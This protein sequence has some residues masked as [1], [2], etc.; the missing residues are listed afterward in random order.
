MKREHHYTLSLKWTGNTGEGTKSYRSYKREHIISI[1]NKPD[2]AAT[3]DPVFLGDKTKHNPEELLLAALSSC[4]MLSYLYLCTTEDIIVTGY[5]D[6]A[7]GVMTDTPGQGGQFTSVTLKPVVTV[8]ESS[9]ID[10]AT[11]LHQ[12]ATEQCYI[13]ASVNFKVHHAPIIKSEK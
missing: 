4:H 2:L 9:M 6:K 1:E 11:A 3:A 13:A 12:K 8:T 10:K 7:S 5:E